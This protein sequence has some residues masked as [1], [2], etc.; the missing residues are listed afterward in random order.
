MNREN[1]HKGGGE[2]QS[3]GGK[4]EEPPRNQAPVEAAGR[5]VRQ[6][7]LTHGIEIFRLGQ[8]L[9]E[10]GT[11]SAGPDEVQAAR[12]EP[13]EHVRQVTQQ[14]GKS[15]QELHLKTQ[16]L[17]VLMGSDMLDLCKIL[18]GSIRDD[19]GFLCQRVARSGRHEG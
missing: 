9:R 6:E 13:A 3:R 5:D 12:S 10:L 19:A 14:R 4:N 11:R 1:E 17:C 2:S 18:A 8:S 16:I 7:L 15:L